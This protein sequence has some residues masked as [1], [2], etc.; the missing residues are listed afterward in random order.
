MVDDPRQPKHQAL[1]NPGNR[2]K[3]KPI[4]EKIPDDLFLEFGSVFANRVKEPIQ[5]VLHEI[6]KPEIPQITG[7]GA[8]LPYPLSNVCDHSSA[9]F[10]VLGQVLHE[11]LTAGDVVQ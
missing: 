1:T 2:I 9:L 10:P 3:R 11:E 7:R 5:P 6:L 4:D 8:V